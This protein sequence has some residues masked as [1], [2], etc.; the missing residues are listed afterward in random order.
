MTDQNDPGSHEFEGTH[1]DLGED[2]LE[3]TAILPALSGQ[4]QP[5]SPSSPPASETSHTDSGVEFVVSAE[6]NPDD[7]LASAKILMGEGLIED[8]KKILHQILIKDSHNIPARLLLKEVQ[9]QELKNIIGDSESRR[10]YGRKPGHGLEEVDPEVLMR[11]LDE[12]LGLGLFGEEPEARANQLSL[13]QDEKGMNAF[14]EQLERELADATVQDWIDLGIAFLEMDLFSVAIRLFAGA[15][16]RIDLFAENSEGNITANVTEQIV[17]SISLLALALILAD[18]PFEA[19]SNM[20][21]LLRDI[22]IKPENKLELFYLM[23]RTYEALKKDELA[24]G[25][26]RQVKEI[27]PDYRDIEQR[28]LRRR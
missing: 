23:G 26:Y 22:E 2:L 7:L 18:R 1:V 10:P 11:K 8:A 21:P 4:V 15:N 16:R 19:I 27:D 12:D 3:K 9:E 13:F 5:A 17:S 28:L 25:Y 24:F 20:Q 6:G 14:C